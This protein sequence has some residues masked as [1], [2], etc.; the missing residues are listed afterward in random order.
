MNFRNKKHQDLFEKE[1]KKLAKNN[2]NSLAVLYL[3]TA[4][5]H[6]WNASKQTSDKGVIELEKVKM[7]KHSRDTYTLLCCAKDIAFGTNYI[8]ILDLGCRGIIPVAT[9]NTII[10]AIHICR[11]G[12]DSEPSVLGEV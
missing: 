8:K 1:Q 5:K 6:L 3:L 4:E 2:K 7:K 12:L 10:T 9:Y 11:N